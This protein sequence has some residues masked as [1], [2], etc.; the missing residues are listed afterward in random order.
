MDKVYFFRRQEVLRRLTLVLLIL[1][2][3]GAAGV[4]SLGGAAA[5]LAHYQ[6]ANESGSIVDFATLKPTIVL[7]AAATFG[8]TL[9][10]VFVRLVLLHLSRGSSRRFFHARDLDDEALKGTLDSAD[11]QL[12]NVVE[13]MALA[14]ASPRPRVFVLDKDTSINSF[15]LA[16]GS[17]SDII[18]VTAGARDRLSRDELQAMVAHEMAHITNG[19]AAINLRLFALIYGF[20]WIY[21]FSVAVI[22]APMRKIEWPGGLVIAVWLTFVFGVFFVM[23]L[24][25][26]GIARI[27]QAAIA[28][29]REYLADASAVQFTRATRGLLGALEKAGAI[30]QAR[31]R[32]PTHTTAFMMF[33]SPYRARSWLLR[34]HP[35][36]EERIEATIAMT[37]GEA[38]SVP[39]LG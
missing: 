26:V 36:I 24:F 37:P 25:G 15:A 33:V 28:R 27:M 34:T 17:R 38:A 8:I 11:R 7:G 3:I 30:R 1:S 22:G 39:A 35:K 21:D 31:R 14:A 12:L 32:R 29:Q 13:E 6:L 5:G 4:A 10:A 16:R 18:G 23:G 2:V 19:D 9:M 20:R